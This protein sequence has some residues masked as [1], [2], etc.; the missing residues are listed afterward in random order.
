VVLDTLQGFTARYRGDKKSAG[1]FLDHGDSPRAKISPR[2]LA[3]Y[4]SIASLI[5][6]LDE[7]ATVQ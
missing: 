5:L 6:N 4:A 2:E 1:E 3:A 7:T